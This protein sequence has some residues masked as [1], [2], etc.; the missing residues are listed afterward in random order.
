MDVLTDTAEVAEKFSNLKKKSHNYLRITRILKYFKHIGLVKLNK[1]ILDKFRDEINGGQLDGN[2]EIKQ[3]LE[4]F[5]E[6]Q[7]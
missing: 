5:W 3:S 2:S 4:K 1:I 7:I 6:K